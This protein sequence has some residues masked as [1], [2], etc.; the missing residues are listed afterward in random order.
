MQFLEIRSEVKVTVTQLWCATLH[1][2][3]MN[4]H[5]KFEIPTSNNKRYAPGTIILKTRSEVN[6]KVTVT[7]KWYVTLH[8]SKMHPH[9]KFR[10]PTSNVL[11]TKWDGQI[12]ERRNSVRLL[13]ASQSFFGG[14]KILSFGYVLDFDIYPHPRHG[15]WGPMSW[16]KS[17]PYKVSMVEV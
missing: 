16:N 13:Y 10:V 1:H 12:F 15:P 7:R 11:D 5:T 8:H 6:D 9:T 2:T 3:K 14:L 17:L 4:P